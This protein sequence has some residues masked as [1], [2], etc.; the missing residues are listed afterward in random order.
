MPAE[1]QTIA[2][3]RQKYSSRKWSSRFSAL[4]Q[5]PDQGELSGDRSECKTNP[6]DTVIL[7][8]GRNACA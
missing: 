8:G 7:E 6:C 2:E 3:G 1:Y 5:N 4:A